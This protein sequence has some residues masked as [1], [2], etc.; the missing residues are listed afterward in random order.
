MD[1]QFCTIEEM[2][3][4][5][6]IPARRIQYLC[7]QGRIERAEKK[8]GVWFIPAD[9]E[10]RSNENQ[11][12]KFVGTKKRLFE[13]AIQLFMLS[14]YETVSIRDIT[15]S[16]GIRQSAA[17]YHFKSKQQIL[18]TIYDYYR[19]YYLQDRPSLKDLEPVLKN[20]TILEMIKS[21]WYDFDGEHRQNLLHITKII[22]QRCAIDEEARSIAK[23]LMMD[24]GLRFVAQVFQRAVD[25]GRLA[26]FDVSSLALLVNSTRM[27][28]ML[29]WIMD[30]S[31]ENTTRA[32]EDEWRVYSYAAKL[33]TDLNPPGEKGLDEN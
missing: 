31:P 10:I 21:L 24:E 17:Y 11:G 29:H 1:R 2:A 22:F 27:F 32:L 3:A 4:K 5:W 30:D 23:T 18:Q 20:G 19:H 9:A 8:A 26:P 15:D 28:S 14:G 7:K 33:L 16:V 25:M 13:S 12:F 6:E